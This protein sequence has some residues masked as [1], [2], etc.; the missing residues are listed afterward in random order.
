MVLCFENLSHTHISHSHSLTLYRPRI[1][2][3]SMLV[4]YVDGIGRS[5][6]IALGHPDPVAIL[7]L[8]FDDDSKS[9][10]QHFIQIS[11]RFSSD[12]QPP[13]RRG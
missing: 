2:L 6:I 5:S 12:H 9:K 3:A 7:V 11:T 1:Y 13:R 10:C 8:Q 4:Q